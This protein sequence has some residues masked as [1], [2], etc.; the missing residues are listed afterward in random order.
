MA[1]PGAAFCSCTTRGTPSAAAARHVGRAT[2]PPVPT[3]TWGLRRS[4]SRTALSVA[5]ARRKGTATRFRADV[6]NRLAPPRLRRTAGTRWRTYPALGTTTASWRVA[7]PAK[8]ISTARERVPAAERATRAS[9][10]AT[11]G[12]TW[13]PVPPAAKSTRRGGGMMMMMGGVGPR[14]GTRRRRRGRRD[15]ARARRPRSAPGGRGGAP[16]ASGGV[17]A[18]ATRRGAR[19]GG[20][21]GDA[22]RSRRGGLGGG[23]PRD[24]RDDGRGPRD[25]RFDDDADARRPRARPARGARAGGARDRRAPRARRG[26]RAHDR[27]APRE[28]RADDAA[29]IARRRVYF[30]KQQPGAGARARARDECNAA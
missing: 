7:V 20:A 12:K 8:W 19:A 30:E 29:S 26:E 1:T 17:A 2:Y 6:A 18:R 23:A 11:A 22:R 3:T 5:C 10:M 24:R 21:R 16:G 4:R 25:E 28:V 9:A 15:R 14:R 27:E 13:P